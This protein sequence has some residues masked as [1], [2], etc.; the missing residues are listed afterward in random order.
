[1]GERDCRFS[2]RG[3]GREIADLVAVSGR[4]DIAEG[5]RLQI[6]WEGV[7]ERDWRFSGIGGERFQIYCE[8]VGERDCRFSGSEWEERDCRFSGREWRKEIGDLVGL[9]ERDCRFSGREW[10]REIADL[11]VV[12]WEELGGDIADL[13]RGIGERDC[14]FSGGIGGGEIAD[15][16]RRSGGERLQ[17]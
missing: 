6:Q 12:Y 1:M 15:L 4:R 16:V 8:G 3:C 10:G 17:I 5:E 7:G 14:R 13:V 2:A 9:G 11:L